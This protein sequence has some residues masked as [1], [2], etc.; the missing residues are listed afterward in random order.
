MY[1]H[2]LMLY[3]ASFIA[4]GLGI[5]IYVLRANITFNIYIRVESCVKLERL[6]VVWHLLVW[7]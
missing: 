7:P 5:N 6:G 4:D 1:L 3:E 2:L